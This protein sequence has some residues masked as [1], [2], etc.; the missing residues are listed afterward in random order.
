M[1][2]KLVRGTGTIAIGTA[3]GQGIILI[4]TP[5]LARIYTPSDFGALALIASVSNIAMA[6]AC[7]RYDLAIPSAEENDSRSLV[8]VAIASAIC[9]AFLVL[10]IDTAIVNLLGVSLTP[11][12]D[13]PMLIALCT[14]LAGINQVA[15]GWAVRLGAFGRVAIVRF[16]QGLGFVSLAAIPSI[17]LLWA[18][19]LSF[20][21][22]LLAFYKTPYRK[23]TFDTGLLVAAR[24]Y[25]KFPRL[26]L[27]GA[28]L[29]VVGYS[30]CI[31]II[32]SNYGVLN[33]GHYAQIQRLLGAP[34]MLIGMSLGQV[35][36]RHSADVAHEPGKL[37]H[38]FMYLLKRLILLGIAVVIFT[39]TVGEMLLKLILGPQW[40]VDT[41]F[42]TPI[43]IAV[44]I[45]ACASPL[46]NI[47]VTVKRL[48]LALRWQVA[49]FISAVTILGGVASH[50]SFNVFI[51]VYAIHE[52]V[53]Y[54]AYL[55][56]IKSAIRSSCAASS[57]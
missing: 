6:A 2:K 41:M 28:V 19:A 43:A 20:V 18:H 52:L 11:P 15:L 48:D 45:R 24:K 25:N 40:R 47:L 33:A 3:L 12:F 23:L 31:W 55:L 26:S 13:S 56:L 36:L 10:F 38:L 14:V 50:H 42:I 21:A 34:L 7:L 17:G 54:S 27:P 22:S 32:T 57:A 16:G 49:Y 8:W 4:A 53:H 30:L 44:A 46:S 5:W 9:M 1:L 37:E 51:F 39:S 29:D 35:L